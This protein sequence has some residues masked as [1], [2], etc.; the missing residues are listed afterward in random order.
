[1]DRPDVLLIGHSF[2][3]RA[4][5]YLIT[6]ES[7]KLHG[8]DISESRQHIAR[9]AAAKAELAHAVRGLYTA[10][11]GI[12]LV[13]D[14]WKAEPSVMNINPAIII[15]H[16]GSNDLSHIVDPQAASALA[17]SVIEFGLRLHSEF[18]VQ[19]VIF[20]S[21]VPRDSHNMSTDADTFLQYMTNYNERNLRSLPQELRERAYFTIIRPG[22]EYASSITDPYLKKYVK[23]LESI[24]RHA[25]RFV[26]NNPHRRN[27]PDEDHNSVTALLEELGWEDLASRRK[28]ARCTLL[29]KV[30][31]GH[32]DVDDELR[33]P[34]SDTGLRSGAS[35]ELKR[36]P[37]SMKKC[38]PYHHSFFPRTVRDW[39]RLPTPARMTKDLEEFKAALH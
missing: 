5:D 31:N 3:R 33:P 13:A 18:G 30:L 21:A 19:T 39:N 22:F 2:I 16:V 15:M 34:Y 24:Q 25:A 27:N 7:G 11:Q 23:R 14:L 26:T 38:E 9:I 37:S 28:D 10:A 8:R 12:N 6:P 35:N 17:D 29:H 36:I 32:V 1:M 20:N 4:R